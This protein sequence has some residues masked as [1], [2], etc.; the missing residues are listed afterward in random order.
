MLKLYSYLPGML[1]AMS[2]LFSETS[3]L[4]QV[5]DPAEAG[6]VALNDEEAY[7]IEA[8]VPVMTFEGKKVYIPNDL[9]KM[10]LAD[11]TSKWSLH[12]MLETPDIVLFWA[13]GFGDNIA[14]APD[15]IECEGDTI[16]GATGEAGRRHVMKVDLA[17]LLTRLQRFYNYFYNDL[18]FVKPGTTKADKYKM[19]VMLDYSL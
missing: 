11:P 13:P 8:E 15:Y 3:A 1:L 17:N 14:E 9:R 16:A 6:T 19:M 5:V 7:C 2:L 4:S 10:D 18:A 12:R